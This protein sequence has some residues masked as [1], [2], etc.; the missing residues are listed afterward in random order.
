MSIE[1]KLAV[2]RLDPRGEIRLGFRCERIVYDAERSGYFA[3]S[4]RKNAGQIEL[5]P[6]ELVE[7][8]NVVEIEI[9]QGAVVLSGGDKRGEL[10]AE[11]GRAEGSPSR[12]KSGRAAA[13]AA[14][15]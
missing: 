8:T 11:L 13:R 2:G 3:I 1:I 5:K 10:P 4:P 12:A 6:T 14:K 15:T 9:E 7:V